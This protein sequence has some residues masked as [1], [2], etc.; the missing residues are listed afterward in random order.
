MSV[1]RVFNFLQLENRAAHE[2]LVLQVDRQFLNEFL[3]DGVFD[4]MHLT[5]D[6]TI[7]CTPLLSTADEEE[8]ESKKKKNL[9]FKSV[10]TILNVLY[11][12]EE[13]NEWYVYLPKVVP[14][15]LGLEICFGQRH[16]CVL[17]RKRRA[18]GKTLYPSQ[19]KPSAATVIASADDDDEPKS[20][21]AKKEETTLR[22]F[23]HNAIYAATS[24]E[25]D[26]TKHTEVPPNYSD[27][28]TEAVNTSLGSTPKHDYFTDESRMLSGVWYANRNRCEAG[29]G[30]LETEARTVEAFVGRYALWARLNA[31]YRTWLMESA[32]YGDGPP[33]DSLPPHT[34]F[35]LSEPTVSEDVV[36]ACRMLLINLTTQQ[37]EMR[38][39]S[40]SHS[41]EWV[42]FRMEEHD[43]FTRPFD[44][45]QNPLAIHCTP[46]LMKRWI[47]PYLMRQ[48]Y[49]RRHDSEGLADGAT[50]L[51][52]DVPSGRWK[53]VDRDGH[54]VR[55][56]RWNKNESTE[57][58]EQRDQLCMLIAEYEKTT[59]YDE[60]VVKKA[61]EEI[62]PFA[63]MRMDLQTGKT[64]IESPLLPQFTILN[65]RDPGK[66]EVDILVF[67][68]RASLEMHV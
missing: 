46:F 43:T 48:M 45:P 17:L 65:W 54:T 29:C 10:P 25:E 6:K 38:L 40:A 42:Q 12:R 33:N 24:H 37:Q 64:S 3:S 4:G 9:R 23:L 19:D 2:G 26:T 63:T 47:D 13:S 27:L 55:S 16:V 11:H 49:D 57:Q 56:S 61:R 51:L 60:R 41:H 15:T 59:D 14:G 44:R 53:T 66:Q 7:S 5:A 28:I 62:K 39:S 58:D 50:T 31:L 22:D 18:D 68:L 67:G 8:D 30:F 32:V 20:K 35:V 1:W 21:H 36:R 34:R 52:V